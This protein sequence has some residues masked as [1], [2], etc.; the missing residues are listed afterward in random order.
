MHYL[1]DLF[2]VT[3]HLP[4]VA[5]P[6]FLTSLHRIH[7]SPHLNSVALSL[8]HLLVDVIFLLHVLRIGRLHLMTEQVAKRFVTNEPAQGLMINGQLAPR[9]GFGDAAVGATKL[10]ALADLY[11]VRAAMTI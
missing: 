10:E 3:L 9:V 4:L 5:L 11:V 1:L 2:L 7:R 8:N 6:L